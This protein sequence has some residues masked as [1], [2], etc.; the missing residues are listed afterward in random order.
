MYNDIKEVIVE[1]LT[2]E[3]FNIILQLIESYPITIVD[4]K[5]QH[6]QSLHQKI[7]HLVDYVNKE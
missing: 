6:I 4:P 1:G 5:L 2:V 7:Q 3:D